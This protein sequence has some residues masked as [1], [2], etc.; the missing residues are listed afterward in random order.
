M[1]QDQTKSS[2]VEGTKALEAKYGCQI[3][4]ILNCLVAAGLECESTGDEVE[5]TICSS[6]RIPIFKVYEDEPHKWV[7]EVVIEMPKARY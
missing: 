4:K 7:V 6:G 1:A 2:I 3:G 5:S